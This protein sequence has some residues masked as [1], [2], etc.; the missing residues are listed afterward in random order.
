MKKLAFLFVV[1][2]FGLWYFPQVTKNR[3]FTDEQKRDFITDV[4]TDVKRIEIPGVDSPYNPSFVKNEEGYLMVFRYDDPRGLNPRQLWEEKQRY[5]GVVKLDQ[6]FDPT[7]PFQTLKTPYSPSQAED[8]RIFKFRKKFYVL[9]GDTTDG[10]QYGVRRLYVGELKEE[11]KI[12]SIHNIVRLDYDNG[13]HAEKNWMPFVKDDEL[14]F[15]YSV[16][17]HKILKVNP[18]TG[19]STVFSETPMP[20]PWSHGIIRGSTPAIHLGDGEYLSFIHSSAPNEPTFWKKK[21]MNYYYMGAY[22]FEDEPPFKVKAISSGPYV[23]PEFYT[24][25]NRKMVIFPAGLIR[26][27]NQL[28]V[29]Y[30]ENDSAIGIAT[31][32]LQKLK[33][34]MISD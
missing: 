4:V 29:S 9:Y 23:H 28:F 15:V 31:I 22:L 21:P 12:F 24:S 5:I 16:S 8:P 10:T 30:G 20:L 7:T 27:G 32:D 2:I 6:N 34:N 14:Y 18:D 26:N 11:K 1:A 19:E 3:T 13:S 33:Q 17:P 25:S